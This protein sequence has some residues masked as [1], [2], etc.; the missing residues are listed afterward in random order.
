MSDLATPP[1]GLVHV[2]IINDRNGWEARGATPL[3]LG[4]ELWD[5]YISELLHKSERDESEIIALAEAGDYLSASERWFD[6]I[7][8]NV[9]EGHSLCVHET[10]VAHDDAAS[11][12]HH[13]APAA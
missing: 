4:R 1:P 6:E 9:G 5:T 2:G 3:A 8:T 12:T 11:T 13:R 10:R 7:G